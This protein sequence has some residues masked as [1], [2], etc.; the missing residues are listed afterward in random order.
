[1]A[2]GD[3]VEGTRILSAERIDVIRA[4]QTEAQ[5]VVVGR[6]D[7]RGLGYMLGGDPACGGRHGPGGAA[8]SVIRAMKGLM[9]HTN[10]NQTT[11]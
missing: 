2:V 9:G 11:W 7:R 5:D 10:S 4:V 3:K 1:M 6:P 8:N